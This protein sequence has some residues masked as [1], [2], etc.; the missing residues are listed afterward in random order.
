MQAM[1][2]EQAYKEMQAEMGQQPQGLPQ[3]ASGQPQGGLA[4]MAPSIFPLTEM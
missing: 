4:Q 2:T 3:M 1:E